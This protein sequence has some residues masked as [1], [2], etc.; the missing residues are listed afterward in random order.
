[1]RSKT[2]NLNPLYEIKLDRFRSYFIIKT[3]SPIPIT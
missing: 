1:M 2:A 3:Y